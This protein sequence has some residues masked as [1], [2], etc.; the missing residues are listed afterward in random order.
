MTRIY[1]IG[2]SPC[3]GKSTV[4]EII[5][6][7]FNL[8]YFKVDDYLYDYIAK[9]KEKGKAFSTKLLNMTVDEIWLRRPVEQKEEEFEI[10]REM[11]EFVINDLR[12]INSPEGIIAEGAA[13]LPELMNHIGIDEYH[14]ICIVPTKEFQYFHYKQRPFVPYVLEGCSNKEQAFENWMERDALF[15]EAVKQSAEKLGYRTI[16][17]DGKKDINYTYVQVCKA[18]GLEE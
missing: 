13:F 17:T 12:Q 10:Y 4:A 14:Y 9:G 3:S 16:V 7:K 1:Y 6:S 15:A 18:F 8:H 5:A 2:G 11:F